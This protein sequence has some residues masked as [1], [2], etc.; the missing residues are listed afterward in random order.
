MDSLG[1]LNEYASE[2]SRGYRGWMAAARGWI[3]RCAGA[4]NDLLAVE[5]PDRS[6]TLSFR[7]I[8]EV[9]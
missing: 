3:Y 1:D 4:Y 8:A 7:D 5:T 2:Y 6:F 9:L